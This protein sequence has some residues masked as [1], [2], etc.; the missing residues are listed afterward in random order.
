[1]S[2]RLSKEDAV[3]TSKAELRKMMRRLGLSMFKEVLKEFGYSQD[4]DDE[5]VQLR[6]EN[7]RQQ[8]KALEI[9]IA[10]AKKALNGGNL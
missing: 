2:R 3:L 7:Q 1:M 4:D 5:H 9:K 10:S 6:I 8:I